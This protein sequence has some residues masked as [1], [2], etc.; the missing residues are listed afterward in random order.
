MFIVLLKFAGNRGEAGTHLEGHKTWLKRGLD[1]GV[2]LLA[3]QLRPD[4]GG[5]ILAHNTSRNDLESRV[6]ADPYV[7]Q[8]VVSAEILEMSPARADA[9][10]S[11]LIE[12]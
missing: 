1:D 6:Q 9:R 7:A 8:Q 3:G 4:L 12:S 5:A 10:L 11:F 2:F